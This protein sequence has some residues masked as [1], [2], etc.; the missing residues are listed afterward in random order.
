VFI[1]HFAVGFASKRLAPR[2]SLAPLLAAPLLCDILW[3]IFLLL[4]VERAT[5]NPGGRSFLTLTF[6]A[7]PWSHSLF[8]ALVWSVVFG[9]LYFAVTRYRAGAMVIGAGVASHWLLD[10]VVHVPDLPLS[11]W[12]S[13]VVGLGLW[14]SVVGTVLVEGAMFVAGV[15]LY[16]TGT[17]ARD[18]IGRW[19]WWGLVL[20]LAVTY[21][22]NVTGGPPP[23]LAVVAWTGLV[24]TAIILWL[25]WWLDRHRELRV[26]G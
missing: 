25:A 1:G 10:W 11:P 3:P 19:A 5:I 4:G 6:T 22:L 26:P 15:W 21:G 8:M 7:Y 24:A 2:A 13:R 9:G 18:G 20:L 23:S 12:G 16:A 14:H 17:R